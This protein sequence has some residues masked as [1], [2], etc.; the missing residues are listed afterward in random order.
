MSLL[1]LTLIF[2]KGMLHLACHERIGILLENAQTGTSAKKDSFAAI[3]GAGIF[4]RV[5]EFTSAG[6]FVFRQW[7]GDRLSHI[8]IFLFFPLF[9]DQLVT[10]H[11]HL[12]L[13]Y[14]RLF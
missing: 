10:Q 7:G 4:R 9:H 2:F 5:F 12:P 1:V 13:Y 14:D 11:A 3:H 8:S 6:G